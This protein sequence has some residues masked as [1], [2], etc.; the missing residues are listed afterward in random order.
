A[1]NRCSWRLAR[2][3]RSENQNGLVSSKE[4]DP[5]SF[6][7]RKIR[8]MCLTV[9]STDGPGNF[10]TLSWPD[11]QGLVA[12]I[13]GLRPNAR[14]V[15]GA[16]LEETGHCKMSATI[17]EIWCG[18]TCNLLIEPSRGEIDRRPKV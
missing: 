18:C 2:S 12:G 11:A 6:T 5:S 1:Q 3:F 17:C 7:C 8:K 15:N 16:R 4:F 10:K 14:T 13:K 9:C